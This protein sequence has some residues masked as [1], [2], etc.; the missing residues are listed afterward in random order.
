M[1]E[2]KEQAEYH[3][4]KATAYEQILSGL[5]GTSPQVRDQLN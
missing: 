3:A 5:E 4:A 2:Q 1:R